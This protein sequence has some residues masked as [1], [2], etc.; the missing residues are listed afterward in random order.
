M[1]PG[2]KRAVRQAAVLWVAMPVIAVLPVLVIAALMTFILYGKPAVG[3]YSYPYLKLALYIAAG[4]TGIFFGWLWEGKQQNQRFW[5]RNLLFFGVFAY[6]LVS[7]FVILSEAIFDIKYYL[8]FAVLNPG[9]LPATACFYFSAR[10]QTVELFLFGFCLYVTYF[11]A[12]NVQVI[13]YKK[14]GNFK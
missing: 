10:Y 7:G 9:F 12:H 5:K 6:F 11:V 2:L 4:I 3:I 8:L 13:L 1:R 14:E